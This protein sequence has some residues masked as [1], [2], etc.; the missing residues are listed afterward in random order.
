MTLVRKGGSL[1]PLTGGTPKIEGI[2]EGVNDN[3]VLVKSQLGGV[4]FTGGDINTSGDI[5]GAALSGSSLSLS[6]NVVEKYLE[7]EISSADI[8]AMN[9]TPV[10]VVPAEA[11]TAIEFVSAVLIYDYDTAA[12]GG[13]G[14]VTLE[15][16]GGAAVTTTVFA[17]NSFG[18]AGDKV[19]SMA[20]LNAAGGYT[21]PVNT[22][23][24]ITNATGAFTDGGTSAGVGRLHVTYRVHTTG[25]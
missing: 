3:D 16:Q 25:L 24:D 18:A 12:Y 4:T 6:D 14:V 10:E 7:V 17:A 13:G 19:F 20:A 5:S 8:L 9:G 2:G 1:Y 21:M 23:L 11:G 15:Y 22:P